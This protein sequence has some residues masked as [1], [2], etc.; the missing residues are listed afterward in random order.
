[1]LGKHAAAHGTLCEAQVAELGRWESKSVLQLSA[2]MDSST[3]VSASLV[4][5][6]AE[7]SAVGA[8]R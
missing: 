7:L 5:V 1:M 8:R 6:M 4:Q 3:A 2:F